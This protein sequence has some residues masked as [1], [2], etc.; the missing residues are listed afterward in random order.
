MSDPEA[1]RYFRQHA[2]R[3]GNLFH[4][5]DAESR[6]GR[7]RRTELAQRRQGCRPVSNFNLV[8]AAQ[9]GKASL[10][11]MRMLHAL[12]GHLPVWPIDALSTARPHGGSLLVEIYTGLISLE[13]GGRAGRS[14]RLS[15]ADLNSGLE[16]LGSPPI[17]ASGAID[18]HSS[19]A[20]IS[21]AWLR[22]VAHDRE[23]WEPSGLTPRLARTE[24]WTFGAL[25]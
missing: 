18:D 10:T 16:A 5:A 17:D 12:R 14:K 13:A 11:G 19:D 4:L 25:W 22:A 1:A 3:E 15:Y 8:G 2:G 24:G 20:L 6:E 23:R 7:F 21:A 9:V